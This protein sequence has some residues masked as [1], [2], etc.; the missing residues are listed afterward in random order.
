[1]QRDAVHANT[2][3]LRC[4]HGPRDLLSQSVPRPL[5]VEEFGLKRLM[6]ARG[7]CV[8]L[9]R[10]AFEDGRWSDKILRAHELGRAAK[11]EERRGVRGASAALD[12]RAGEVAVDALESWLAQ[13][14]PPV[15][16]P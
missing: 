9:D 5:F 16:A 2:V 13:L 12:D 8:H 10:S 3:R 15:A 11:L 14:S 6:L 4:V 1:M 7:V